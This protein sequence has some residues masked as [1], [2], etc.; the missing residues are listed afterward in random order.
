MSMCVYVY[1]WWEVV[2]RQERNHAV[3]KALTTTQSFLY[4]GCYLEID[5]RKPNK[6]PTK[7]HEKLR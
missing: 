2:V 3:S 4:L 7:G 6:Y 1:W 5:F